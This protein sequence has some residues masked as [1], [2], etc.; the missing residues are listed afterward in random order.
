MYSFSKKLSS[1]TKDINSA[2]I[3]DAGSAYYVMAQSAFNSRIILPGAQGEMGFTLPASVGVSLADKDLNVFGITGDGSFQFNIQELQTIVQ[4][5]LPIKIIVLNNSGYLSI[6][7]TQK[8]Y[9]NERY[10]G[11][12][13][14][15][16]ISFPDCSKIAKAYG[17][18]YFRINEI[19]HLDNVLPEVVEYDSF[20][21]CE[22]ICPDNEN[23]VP[24]AASRQNSNGKI[25]SQPLENMFPFLSDEVFKQE[26]IIEPIE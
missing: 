1:L 8:K 2:I 9:F 5:R 23:I 11:T 20:C 6:K 18:K 12:D 14:N 19:E 22:V 21:I 17:M 3:S 15:S 13:S 26:M 7:N 4:N 24:S 25:V 16:G 10:S